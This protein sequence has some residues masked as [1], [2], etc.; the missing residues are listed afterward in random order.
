MRFFCSIA[1]LASLSAAASAQAPS[2]ERAVPARFAGVYRV[3]DGTLLPPD[4]PNGARSG[5]SV[6]FNNM[7]HT[8]YFATPNPG[9][10]WVDE[11]GLLDRN[12]CGQDQ[13]NGFDLPYCSAE[14]DAT[15]N[16][17][18]LTIRFYD[19]M[20]LCSGPPA[21]P[22]ANCGYLI[23]GVPLGSPTGDTRCW[24]LRVDLSGGFECPAT[25][26]Q[27]F[28]T[29]STSMLFGW[30]IVVHQPV[31]GPS[32]RTGGYLTYD[33]VATFARPGGYLGCRSFGFFPS[34]RFGMKMYGPL[35]NGMRY[36]SQ[37]PAYPRPLDTLELITTLPIEQ[38]RPATWQVT[39]PQAGRSYWL[40]LST[41]PQDRGVL[42]GQGTLLVSLADMATAQPIAM[43]NGVGFLNLP[44]NPPAR[45]YVQAVETNGPF[46][47]ANV[48]AL[49][50]G[51]T[52]C[53]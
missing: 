39:A 38:G 27:S 6:L 33:T 2:L 36:R 3:A 21:W 15:G 19:E 22:A 44:F 37:D 24:T 16:S 48:T 4:A 20:A 8:V 26:A 30:S 17:G 1:F 50:N 25:L 23:T 49:S 10:E 5:P 13:I 18:T 41:L 28:G 9:E 31:T 11:G 46:S 35:P 42:G 12:P 40:V 45:L 34:A 51:M 53:F 29:A 52:H 7:L 43:P 47:P 32:L 14:P